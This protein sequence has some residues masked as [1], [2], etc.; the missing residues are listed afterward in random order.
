MVRSL[1]TRQICSR[2]L[3]GPCEPLCR[4][5]SARA[6]AR[7]GHPGFSK[8][9]R[10]LRFAAARRFILDANNYCTIF[11]RFVKGQKKK[12]FRPCGATWPNQLL[13]KRLRPRRAPEKKISCSRF[14]RLRPNFPPFADRLQVYTPQRK[15]RLQRPHKPNAHQTASAL[16]RHCEHSP[17]HELIYY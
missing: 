7:A 14:F 15:S 10:K 12:I 16:W 11:S 13:T 5:A 8:N 9:R 2:R 4:F 6:F 1:R 3:A 17:N